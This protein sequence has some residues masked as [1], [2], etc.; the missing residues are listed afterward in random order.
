MDTKNWFFTRTTRN[1]IRAE[2]LLALGSLI[3]ALVSH[4]SEVN[5]IAAVILYQ[6]IDTIGLYPGVI[7]LRRSETG[8]IGKI[9]YILYNVC[10]SAVVQGILIIFLWLIFGWRWE[11]LAVPIHLCADRGFFNNFPKPFGF[12]FDP[13]ELPAFAELKQRYAGESP[14]GVPAE[15][16][17]A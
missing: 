5:W 13:V 1:H 7:A 4:Y 11:F 3:V 10:H 14:T 17:E 8:R 12:P 16:T 6:Y 9:Y 15:Y 2:Y